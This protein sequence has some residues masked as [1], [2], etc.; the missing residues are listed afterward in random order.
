[1]QALNLSMMIKAI[2]INNVI[3]AIENPVGRLNG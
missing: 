2:V 3:K 1:M